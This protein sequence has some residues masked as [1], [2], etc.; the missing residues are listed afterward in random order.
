MPDQAPANRSWV[1]EVAVKVQFYDLDPLQ[2]VWHGNYARFFELARCALLDT[3]GYNYHQMRESGY[4][5]PVID[6]H[7]R[8]L[9][10]ATFAQEILV[11]AELVEWEHRLK[12]QYLIRDAATGLRM[13][14]GSTVQVAVHI[15]TNQMCLQSP[16]VL[17]ERLGLP[18][19]W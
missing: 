8:Y 4:A 16:R 10:P 19:P 14:K 15:E 7:V 17:F 1:A 5:W 9:Q 12:L 3:I 18:E 13:T 2:I 6:M 11:R